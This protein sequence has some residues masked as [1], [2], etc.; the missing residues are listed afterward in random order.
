MLLRDVS[1]DDLKKNDMVGAGTTFCSRDTHHIN[2]ENWVYG[3]T[4]K[5]GILPHGHSIL[6]IV[7]SYPTATELTGYE[8]KT[9]VD[10]VCLL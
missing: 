9:S 10:L 5:A 3:S 6:L 7:V 2:V 4:F 8:H 1:H